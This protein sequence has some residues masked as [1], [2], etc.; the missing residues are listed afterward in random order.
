MKQRLLVMNGRCILEKQVDDRWAVEKVWRAGALKPGVYNFYSA[1]V[2]DPQ[3][4]YTGPVIYVD[5]ERVFQLVGKQLVLHARDQFEMTPPIAVA[6]TIS[7]R[8]GRA[9][10]G[11]AITLSRGLTR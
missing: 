2:A 5:N 6:K 11:E 9:A 3:K 4:S 7:Y 10:L 1:L 8:D